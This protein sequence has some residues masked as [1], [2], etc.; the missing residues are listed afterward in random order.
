MLYRISSTAA[1]SIQ[2]AY[3]RELRNR[4]LSDRSE[5]CVI[6][7]DYLIISLFNP[8]VKKIHKYMLPSLPFIKVSYE[9]SFGE[10]LVPDRH[11]ISNTVSRNDYSMIRLHGGVCEKYL[12]DHTSKH[13]VLLDSVLVRSSYCIPQSLHEVFEFIVENMEFVNYIHPLFFTHPITRHSIENMKRYI[14]LFVAIKCRGILTN[15]T[16]PKQLIDWMSNILKLE[17]QYVNN[18][19][20]DMYIKDKPSVFL[21]DLMDM[22][23]ITITDKPPSDS[24]VLTDPILYEGQ[25]DANLYLDCDYINIPFFAWLIFYTNMCNCKLYVNSKFFTF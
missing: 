2:G 4:S 11:Y 13:G 7:D 9:E 5:F 23:N 17:S 6:L 8:R 15:G 16:F 25:S 24:I 19:I 20:V 21:T 3:K 14:P 18:A 10:M 12:Y 22:Y 1:L